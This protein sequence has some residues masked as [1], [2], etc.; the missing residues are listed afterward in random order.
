MVSCFNLV[1]KQDSKVAQ[2]PINRQAN[3]IF[4]NKFAK[5]IQMVKSLDD[6]QKIVP[7]KDERIPAVVRGFDH[8]LSPI[9]EEGGAMEAALPAIRIFGAEVERV[10]P[11]GQVPRQILRVVRQLEEKGI[12]QEGIFRV[13]ADPTEQEQIRMSMDRNY[14]LDLSVY[15]PHSLATALKKYFQLMPTPIIPPKTY[16]ALSG[17]FGIINISLFLN[18][19]SE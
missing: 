16:D 10:E 12:D 14:D 1:S 5:K 19:N 18:F 9:G 2:I 4:S 17:V 8:G 13:A 11:S 3:L 6:L 7:I 15:S